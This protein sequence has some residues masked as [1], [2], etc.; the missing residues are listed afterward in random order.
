MGV[1]FNVGD[2]RE[3]TG[4]QNGAGAHIAN[5]IDPEARGSDR[6]VPHGCRRW[7][8]FDPEAMTDFLSGGRLD[9]T[10]VAAAGRHGQAAHG[11]VKVALL[12]K[13]SI[14][15]GVQQR[16]ELPAKVLG[17]SHVLHTTI[18]LRDL[19][20]RSVQGTR[21]P[22]DKREFHVYSPI[23]HSRSRRTFPAILD[24]LF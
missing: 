14:V 6:M 15:T 12:D 3:N 4:F 24:V 22:F 20:K 2:E 8:A 9:E 21:L 10:D 1:A 19:N 18:L 5:P 16:V 23:F 11:F 7:V 13:T 17:L